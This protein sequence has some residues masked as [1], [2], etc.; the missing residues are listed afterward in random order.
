MQL[1]FLVRE[2]ILCFVAQALF[3]SSLFVTHIQ[4]LLSPPY[5]LLNSVCALEC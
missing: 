4:L 1:T 5:H 2:I 3:D